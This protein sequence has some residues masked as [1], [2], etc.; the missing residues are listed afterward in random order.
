MDVLEWKAALMKEL[1]R[2]GEV[3]NVIKNELFSYE[4]GTPHL[5]F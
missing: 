1:F 2:A 4:M 3:N 5:K